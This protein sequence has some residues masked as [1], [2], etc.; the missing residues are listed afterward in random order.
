MRDDEELAVVALLDPHLVG[1]RLQRAA[2]LRQLEALA[3]AL[4]AA[5]LPSARPASSTPSARSA[6]LRRD[7]AVGEALGSAGGDRV[8]EQH[9]VGESVD[10]DFAAGGESAEGAAENRPESSGGPTRTGSRR[11]PA[12][13]REP[14][15]DSASPSRACSGR[16]MRISVPRSMPPLI[17]KLLESAA[18]RVR[19]MRRLGRSTSGRGRIPLP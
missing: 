7:V 5:A 3:Q 12:A 15:S 4:G 11:A 6:M 9:R 10:A 13:G 8:A 1:Q 17:S 18:I 16:C 14:P 19:P 2:Q